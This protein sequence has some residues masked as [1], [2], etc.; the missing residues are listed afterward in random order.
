TSAGEIT[1]IQGWNWYAG[2]DAGAVGSGQYDFETA[3]T[4]ELGHA[5]GLGHSANATSVMHA[6]LATAVAERALT[7]ADL[8]I[9]DFDA[10]ADA[11]HAA[12]PPT[13]LTNATKTEASLAV[14]R[15]FDAAPRPSDSA[16]NLF[17][18]FLGAEL[19]RGTVMASLSG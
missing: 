14:G 18:N 5:L 8:A 19:S 16:P 6:S 7:S 4:H 11:L 9:P 12:A 13:D 2:S 10:G 15:S 3:V 17:L 1:L